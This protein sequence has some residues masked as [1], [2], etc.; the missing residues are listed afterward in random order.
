M[1]WF[2]FLIYIKIS[3]NDQRIVATHNLD[4]L[5]YQRWAFKPIPFTGN[6]QFCRK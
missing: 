3:T 5:K 6:F 2:A 1:I 4:L